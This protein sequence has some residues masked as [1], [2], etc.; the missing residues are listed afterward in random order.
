MNV[1]QRITRS[2][3]RYPLL[4]KDVDFEHSRNKVLNHLFFTNGNGMAWIDGEIGYEDVE[5]AKENVI[6]PEDYFITPIW[7]REE[8]EPDFMNEWR[9]KD[10]KAYRPHEI[11][12]KHSVTMYPLCKYALIL[13]IPDD[14]RP[15]WLEA[16]R[17]AVVMG[18]DYFSDPYKHGRDTYVREWM[19]SR[20][21]DKIKEY[22]K[23]QIAYLSVASSRIHYLHN[24]D[25][26]DNLG[27]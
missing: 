21:Y 20:Q 5:E 25:L 17:D 2:I 24:K 10:G 22:L 12:S 14:V 3:L 23:T 26:I 13:H 4:Y 7:S 6:I 15:D 11:C 19:Q 27:V 9:K 16:A 8:D 18:L 1:E